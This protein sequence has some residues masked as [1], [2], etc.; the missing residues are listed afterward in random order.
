MILVGDGGPKGGDDRVADELLDG[1]SAERNLGGHR[2][3]EAVEEVTGVLRVERATQLGRSDEVGKQNAR[4]LALPRGRFGL[5][6]RRAARTETRA[7]RQRRRAVRA[8]SH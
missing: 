4:E 1:A 5:E 7:F 8:A 3:V 6:R 2:L